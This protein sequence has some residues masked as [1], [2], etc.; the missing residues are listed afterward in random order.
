MMMFLFFNELYTC[1]SRIILR[2]YKCLMITHNFVLD[3]LCIYTSPI[4]ERV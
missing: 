2:L 4:I 1:Y 3:N